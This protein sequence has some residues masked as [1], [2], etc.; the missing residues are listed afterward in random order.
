MDNM[1]I[2][3]ATKYN[4]ACLHIHNMH[5]NTS[6]S[7]TLNLLLVMKSNFNVIMGEQNCIKKVRD[8]I[9]EQL[10]GVSVMSLKK[11]MRHNK[12]LAAIENG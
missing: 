11:Y 12:G 7:F 3:I 6:Y 1:R 9:G 4:L 8:H 5:Q 10:L 2:V